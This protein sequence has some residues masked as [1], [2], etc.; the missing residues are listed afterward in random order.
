MWKEINGNKIVY[1]AV[2][3]NGTKCPVKTGQLKQ[4]ARMF[5]LPVNECAFLYYVIDLMFHLQYI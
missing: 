4:D 3:I 2:N 5:R 1:A